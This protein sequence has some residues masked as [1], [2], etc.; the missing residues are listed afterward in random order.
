M[1]ISDVKRWHWMAAAIVVGLA[2][3]GVRMNDD[4]SV[5]LDDYDHIFTDAAQ[6]ERALKTKQSGQ[7]QLIDITV[8]PYRLTR[9]NQNTM[10]VYLV[11]GLYWDGSV[12]VNREGAGSATYIPACFIAT[13]PYVPAAGAKGTTYPTVMAY[14]DSLKSTGVSYRYAWWWWLATPLAIWLAGSILIIGIIWPTVINLIVFRSLVRPAETPGISLSDVKSQSPK[15][16]PPTK[17]EPLAEVMTEPELEVAVNSAAPPVPA[18]PPAVAVLATS[19]LDAAP[20]VSSQT[21]T[22]FAARKDDFYPTELR[23]HPH[24]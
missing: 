8:F 20:E 11:T 22:E 7:P 1:Q 10:R 17:M 3:G 13:C 9:A 16:P 15:T 19:P 5:S 6:F 2:C 14:L 23:G 4:S 12:R 24:K 21:P 18:P